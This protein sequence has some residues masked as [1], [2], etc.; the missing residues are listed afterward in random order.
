MNKKEIVTMLQFAV[1]NTA[2]RNPALTKDVA[3]RI[4]SL[5]NDDYMEP[6]YSSASRILKVNMSMNF[7][8]IEIQTVDH[9]DQDGGDVREGERVSVE[10]TSTVIYFGEK[11]K[12]GPEPYNRQGV[13]YIPLQWSSLELVDERE[14]CDVY[15]TLPMKCNTSI[16][17]GRF[18]YN[19]HWNTIEFTIVVEQF[20]K[21]DF[22]NELFEILQYSNK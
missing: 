20:N 13:Q 17:I 1:D 11:G 22:I 2:A 3:D 8:S 6:N 21:D 18:N 9:L 10:G 15:A 7:G 5:I 4:Y 14:E 16:E 19:D 12:K